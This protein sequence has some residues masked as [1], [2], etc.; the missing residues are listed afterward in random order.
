MKKDRHYLLY[1][2]IIGLFFI[3]KIVFAQEITLTNEIIHFDKY[4]DF[5]LQGFTVTDKYLVAILISDD[6][7][8]SIIK[9]YDKENFTEI[10]SIYGGSL[11]HAND[12]TYNN[13]NNLL[14]V[15]DNGNK[16]VHLFEATSLKYL[17]TIESD[18]TLR[19]LTY[20]EDK[21]YFVARNF[22]TGY[23]LDSDLKLVSQKPFI[24]GLNVSSNIARQGWAY[25]QDKIYYATWSWIRM[26]GDGTSTIYVYNLKGNKLDELK[27]AKEAGELV[28]VAF[29]DDMILLGFNGYDN[30]VSFYLEKLDDKPTELVLEQPDEKIEDEKTLVKRKPYGLVGLVLLFLI[31]LFI[32]RKKAKISKS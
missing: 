11:G 26:G 7:N 25:W 1:L 2:G 4:K 24:I 3:S 17:K 14:Y 5:D 21:D 13:E 31:S 30:Y 27:I 32:I 28:D 6:E 16:D 22:T 12:I 20:V 9:V 23:I 8:E 10:K 15:I 18:I 19:S 29:M